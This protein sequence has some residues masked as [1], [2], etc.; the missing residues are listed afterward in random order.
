MHLWGHAEGHSA[1]PRAVLE[2]PCT[3][4]GAFP[5]QL[6]PFFDGAFFSPLQ[7]DLVR[8]DRILPI[9]SLARSRN[10]GASPPAQ[11][12]AA[13][14]LQAADLRLAN[15]L[16]GAPRI[17]GELLKLGI[18]IGQTTVAKYMARNR[19]PPSQ[20]WK[21]FLRNHAD[22]IASLDLF[23]VPTISFQL[24]YG[25]LILKHGR[26]EILCLAAT[27]HP[28]AEW[29][30]RQLMEAYGWE[31]GPCYLVR[32]RDRVYGEV[33]IRRLRAMGIRD[34]PTAPRSPWQNGYC[35]RLIGSIRRECLDHIVVF[36][37][38]HLRHLLRVYADYYN[39]TRT[40]LSLN[41]TR[42]HRGTALWPSGGARVSSPP[43]RCSKT[44][45]QLAESHGRT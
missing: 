27:A 16:W 8:A 37:E 29:I 6:G 12:P 43:A 38:R 3:V 18:T 39:R 33:F 23:V 9:A 13:E 7:A 31:E 1:Q 42:P 14:V 24:L 20:G 26:R 10:L 41:T 11:C 21:T 28:S 36:G 4:P 34:R 45:F 15:P 35:E 40:H 2:L 32:D 44:A 25:L 5:P 30:S 19:R 17:H 22:G